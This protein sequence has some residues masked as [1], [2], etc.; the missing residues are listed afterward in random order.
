MT[1][2]PAMSSE[3]LK[4]I[5]I[6]VDEQGTPRVA[7]EHI[8]VVLDRTKDEEVM[9]VSELPFRVDFGG[10]S[11]FYESQF[12]T[13]YRR[14]GLVRRGVLSSQFRTYEYTIEING[15]TLDPKIKIFP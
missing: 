8:A 10:D 7:D 1:A 3:R 13:A 12:N 4:T 15:K 9:W 11:P 6:K 14:S 5:E 2:Q